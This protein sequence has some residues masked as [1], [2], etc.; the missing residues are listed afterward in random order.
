M[1][2]AIKSNPKTS[3][4]G[5][6][7]IISEVIRNMPG[8]LDF[9]PENIGKY[10][11][12]IASIVCATVTVM[13]ARDKE[14]PAQLEAKEEKKAVERENLKTEIKAE[15]KEVAANLV[16]KTTQNLQESVKEIVKKEIVE[17]LPSHLEDV[18]GHRFIK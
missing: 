16:V 7:T 1:I 13:S 10:I 2:V 11:F 18:T 15:A 17:T 5:L 3:L 4:W 9:L 6:A 8:L 12:G 14:T